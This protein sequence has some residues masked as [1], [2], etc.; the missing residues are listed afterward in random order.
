MLF[1]LKNVQ[2]YIYFTILQLSF[3]FTQFTYFPFLENQQTQTDRNWAIIQIVLYR[4]HNTI[5]I[6][7]IINYTY[8][9]GVLDLEH[10][11]MTIN[12]ILNIE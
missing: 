12:R 7:G 9:S 5:C 2:R 1:S 8:Q 3:A 10:P 11:F 4:W 6:G